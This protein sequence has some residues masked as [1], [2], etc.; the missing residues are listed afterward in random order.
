MFPMQHPSQQTPSYYNGSRKKLL[1]YLF[2]FFMALSSLLY[3]YQSQRVVFSIDF[4]ILL[5]ILCC[6]FSIF[7]IRDCL[8]RNQNDFFDPGL[9]FICFVLCSV[10]P[11]SIGSRINLVK[12]GHMLLENTTL[13][14]K[15]TL[16]HVFLITSFTIGY[17]IINAFNKIDPNRKFH[18]ISNANTWL[19][20]AIIT[21]IGNFLLKLFTGTFFT[22]GYGPQH[23][24]SMA[25][26][27]VGSSLF[28]QIS[29]HFSNISGFAVIFTVGIIIGNAPTV[30]KARLRIVM[31][32]F[33]LFVWYFG[34]Y[35]N[36]GG[37]MVIM[38]SAACY[39]DLV[40]WKG[41]LLNA[42]LLVILIVF[43]ALILQGANF[44]EGYV[45]DGKPPEAWKMLRA[46]SIDS[47]M[48]VNSSRIIQWVD[49][50]DTELLDYS[51]YIEGV[52]S[53][54]PIQ[55]RGDN[56]S[57]SKWYA[58]KIMPDLAKKGYRSAFSAVAEGYLNGYMVGVIVHGIVL[59]ILASIINFFKLNKRLWIFGPLFF[60]GTFRLTY[61]FYRSEFSVPFSMLKNAIIDIFIVSIA[62]FILHEVTIKIK[63][64]S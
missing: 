37:V 32:T 30:V 14:S 8:A 10:L 39:A 61:W 38:L 33:L 9:F 40:F 11:V 23:E 24:I 19:I 27:S 55:L 3:V 12:P 62:I 52:K 35:G 34:I 15:V 58:W 22:R 44:I 25:F 5:L 43:G 31:I 28:Q 60:A 29:T 45:K 48:M 18:K 1:Y 46:L 4:S 41:K 20:V 7:A 21:H 53:L 64:I 50:D 36:R 51:T 26:L 49:N 6:F 2:S 17:L 63:S 57:L 47:G 16:A 59:S 13:M 56:F 54:I 42:K